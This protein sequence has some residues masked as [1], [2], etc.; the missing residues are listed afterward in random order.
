MNPPDNTP[1]SVFVDAFGRKHSAPTVDGN[2]SLMVMRF[3]L[4]LRWMKALLKMLMEMCR[5]SRF[6]RG[7]LRGEFK[8]NAYRDYPSTP[9]V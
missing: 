4:P 1:K 2:L 9:Y 8:V 3:N 6:K 7:R 5:K